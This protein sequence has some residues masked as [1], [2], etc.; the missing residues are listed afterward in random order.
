M[1]AWGVT[2]VGLRRR[3]N[4]DSYALESFG[5]PDAIVAVVC[6]GMGGVSGGRLASTLAVSTYLD[7]LHA[8][9]KPEMTVEQVRELQRV[10]V[11]RAN[12]AVYE[13]SRES[14]EYRGMGTTLVSAV[15]SREV[16]VVANVGDSRA[17]HIG[18]QGIRRVSQDHSVVAEMVASGEITAEQARTHPNR[19]LITRA[20]GPGAE[21]ACDTYVV[22]LAE[23]DC[24]LLCTDGMTGTAL[25][26]ELLDIVRAAKD[27]EAALAALIELAKRRGAPDNVT[28]VLI[29]SGAEEVGA[30]G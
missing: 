15:V 21:V 3:E 12:R 7:T 1:K 30:D 11:S 20:L 19:N 26:E 2:D 29:R 18:A 22:P 5:A 10:C 9:A 28:A 13:R 23:G 27:G 4:Q 24:L 14:A 16:A 17:Y 8:L 6:D 25:D